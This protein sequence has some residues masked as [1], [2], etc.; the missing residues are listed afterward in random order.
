MPQPLELVLAD[1]L[2]RASVL[3]SEGYALQAQAIERVV[4][5]VRDSM[6]PYLEILSERNAQL[7]SGFSTERLRG[8]FPEWEARGLAILD[9][10]GKRTYRAIA[11]PVRV[12]ESTA[13]LAGARG[14]SLRAASGS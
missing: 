13:R 8:R 14:E 10:K 2:E 4:G 3:R 1:A 6:A 11:L 7:R 9:E 12:E 5:E